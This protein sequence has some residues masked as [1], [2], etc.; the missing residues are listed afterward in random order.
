MDERVYLNTRLG[1]STT[2]QDPPGRHQETH[3]FLF[4]RWRVRLPYEWCYLHLLVTDAK[5][6]GEGGGGCGGGEVPGPGFP[7][8]CYL[9]TQGSTC[10]D[11]LHC[12]A[13]LIKGI[14]QS[15]YVFGRLGC[16]T[17]QSAPLC[18]VCRSLPADPF[19]A[20][21]MTGCLAAG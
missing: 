2:L 20:D 18:V 9:T 3:G 5:S 21:F 16:A 17:H 12:A 1:H 8:S 15:R 10:S 6:G 13:D 7:S 14:S 4:R 11:P 19:L